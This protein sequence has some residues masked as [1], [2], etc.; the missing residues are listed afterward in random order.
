MHRADLR[1]YLRTLQGRWVEDPSNE[2]PR[3]DRVRMRRLVAALGAEGIGAEALSA[4][5]RRL[6][7]ETVPLR[8]AAAALWQAQ[9]AEHEAPAGRRTGVLRLS[10]DWYR[11]ADRATQRRLLSAIVRFV[12]GADYA[13]RG[14]ALETFRDRLVS[15]GGGT[16]HG[17]MATIARDAVWLFRE[18]A[19]VAP[20]MSVGDATLWD[21]RW[22]VA[23]G[24][25]PELSVGALGEA[26][27]RQA[28]GSGATDLPYRAALSLPALWDGDTLVACDALGVG[29]GDTVTFCPRGDSDLSLPA[30][31]DSH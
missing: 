20:R 25:G 3:F 10:P 11:G 21:N 19:A 28:T 17:C 12:S 24:A 31:L 18:A 5:A 27:W 30:F 2:D 16:V 23:Q 7:E 1:H 13:P 29:P 15:G 6:A 9:G 8:R 26:G 4:A 22:R 14:D